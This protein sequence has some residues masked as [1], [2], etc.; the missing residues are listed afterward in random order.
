MRKIYLAL[1]VVFL[2]GMTMAQMPGAR[3]MS[4]QNMN[5]GH[6]YGKVVD[7]NTNK[8]LEAASIQLT[9]NRMDT[10]T[11]TKRDFVIAAL[12][13][14]KKGE[15]NIDKLPVR[16]SFQILITAIGF[17]PYHETISFDLKTA[18][19]DMSQMMSAVDKDLGNIKMKHDAKQ[20]EGVVV[21][22]NKNMLQM[23]IDRKV[24]NVDKS[25]TSVG[26]TAVDVMKN[27]PSVNVDIDGNVTLRNASPQI[28]IDGR[29][30]TLTLEQIP[31]DEI[32]SVEIITNPSAKFDA[33]GGGSGILNIVLKKN[34]KAG[35]NGNLR[36][37]VDSRLKFGIGADVNVKQG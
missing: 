27:V 8:P 18:G 5:P 11:K 34:R 7:A 28:F 23:N 36:A 29:P 21:T 32:E 26:G 6:F 4:G 30:T 15:F 13:T 19:G 2:S 31:A 33:S 25:L 14:D 12:L 16:G 10:A 9:Q 3:N 22:A 37:N 35:Y 1:L 17:A 24:F 20:L